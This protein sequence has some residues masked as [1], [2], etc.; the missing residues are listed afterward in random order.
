MSPEVDNNKFEAQELTA[1]IFHDRLSQQINQF[2]NEVFTLN[3]A[4]QTAL[5]NKDYN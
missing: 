3:R 4:L 5:N 1:S 2:T